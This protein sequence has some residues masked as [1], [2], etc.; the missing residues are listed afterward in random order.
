MND[1]E[2]GKVI[3]THEEILI[4]ALS[5]Y[6]KIESKTNYAEAYKMKDLESYRTIGQLGLFAQW[7]NTFNF[8]LLLYNGNVFSGNLQFNLKVDNEFGNSVVP[9]FRLLYQDGEKQYQINLREKGY[10]FQ[11]IETRGDYEERIEY[12]FLS[13]LGTG[14]LHS[15]KDIF[16]QGN[17]KNKYYESH[18]ITSYQTNNINVAINH[19]EFNEIWVCHNGFEFERKCSLMAVP[20]EAEVLNNFSIMHNL[21]RTLQERIDRLIHEFSVEKTSFLAK[22]IL[23]GFDSFSDKVIFSSFG[24]NKNEISLEELYFGNNEKAL[25]LL[26]EISTSK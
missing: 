18:F 14:I 13:F 24:L 8:S 16:Y 12:D 10:L 11:F 21:D 1:V 5:K 15:K 7:I 6:G 4:S 2:V 20:T 26:K 19:K 9:H 22:F 3:F 25:K 17:E 23:Y